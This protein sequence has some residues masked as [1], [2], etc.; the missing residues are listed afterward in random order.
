MRMAVVDA[1]SKTVRLFVADVGRH[2]LSPVHT[3]KWRLRLAEHVAR[4]GTMSR[5]GMGQLAHATAAACRK[6]RRWGVREPIVFATAVVRDAPNRPRILEVIGAGC[7]V[8]VHLLPGER[9]SE[10]TYLAARRWTGRQAGPLAV[11]D[12]GGG[13]F[14]VAYGDG[15]TADIAVSLPLGAGRLTREHFAGQDPPSP[16]QVKDL[17]RYVRGQ[18]AEVSAQVRDAGPRTVVATSRTFDQLSRLCS[19][20]GDGGTPGARRLHQTPLRRAIKRLRRL[21]AADRARLPGVSAARSAQSLAGAIVAETA[22][23]T[24]EVDPVLICP[25][26]IREGVLLQAFESPDRT[27]R[28][29]PTG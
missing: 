11:L 28:A 22:M 14:E 7:D 21:P 26:A 3:V 10:L 1:G 27:S 25:W 20:D 2:G 19:P 29:L 4:D 13:S 12:I 9:E 17:R 15:R 5:A 23:R 8:P 6:S 24:M 18:L 16:S